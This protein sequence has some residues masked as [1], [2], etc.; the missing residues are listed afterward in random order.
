VTTVDTYAATQTIT[1]GRSTPATQGATFEDAR[2][3]R[4]SAITASFDKLTRIY[5]ELQEQYGRTLH[6]PR[7]ETTDTEIDNSVDRALKYTWFDASGN[8]TTRAATDTLLLPSELADGGPLLGGGSGEITAMPVLSDGE[9]IVGDGTT[10]PVAESGATLRTSIGVGTTD[11][12]QFT[13][14]NLGSATDTTLTGDG[15]VLSVEGNVAYTATGTD[16]PITDGGTGASTSIAAKTSLKMPYYYVDDYAVGDGDGHGGGTDDTIAINTVAELAAQTN[17]T[18]IW[19]D[20]IYRITDSIWVTSQS[21]GYTSCSWLGAVGTH[22]SNAYGYGTVIDATDIND[23]PAIVI[24]AARGVTI[25]GI[26]LKGGNYSYPDD[27]IP[28][29][30][31]PAPASGIVYSNWIDPNYTSDRDNPYAG[32]CIDP[33]T[34]ADPGAATRYGDGSD[35]GLAASNQVRIIQCNST[36]FVVAFCIGPNRNSLG[37]DGCSFTACTARLSATGL[38]CMEHKIKELL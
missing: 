8:L 16:V 34:N 5:Q 6:I 38:A 22:A 33:Y 14:V 26:A 12:P 10:D 24:Q 36:G 20:K 29:G 3:L 32:F 4:L 25:S 31:V 35:Y 21:G 27:A 1:I 28:G 15:G 19:G 7:G 18:L 37:G 17:G 23:L 11:S 30:G 9:M 2:V 13:A